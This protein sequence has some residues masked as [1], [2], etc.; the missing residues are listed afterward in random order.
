MK[1]A[2]YYQNRAYAYDFISSNK[3]ALDDINKSIELF[4]GEENCKIGFFF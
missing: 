1:L 3:E 2:F 4:G